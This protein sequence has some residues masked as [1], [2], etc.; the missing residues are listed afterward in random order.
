MKFPCSELYLVTGHNSLPLG[1]VVLSM[2]SRSLFQVHSFLSHLSHAA[3]QAM[4]WATV[5]RVLPCREYRTISKNAKRLG[6]WHWNAERQPL[7]AATKSVS[8]N[9]CPQTRDSRRR[10]ALWAEFL[11]KAPWKLTGSCDTSRHSWS[12]MP[13]CAL[14]SDS[15]LWQSCE[16][17]ALGWDHCHCAPSGVQVER[18]S[19]STSDEESCELNTSL[20]SL[21]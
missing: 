9:S 16:K 18:T 17:P 4:G 10:E 11:T 15:G 6:W 8:S 3:E 14:N 2:G 7:I 5:Q 19:I 13:G 1:K 21:V 12:W 20:V